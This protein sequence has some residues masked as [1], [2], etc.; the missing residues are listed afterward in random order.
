MTDWYQSIQVA[1]VGLYGP[2]KEANSGRITSVEHRAV[3]RIFGK[4]LSVKTLLCV[5][6]EKH[7]AKPQ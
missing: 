7:E 4:S 2:R 6:I 1:K 5:A 3:E